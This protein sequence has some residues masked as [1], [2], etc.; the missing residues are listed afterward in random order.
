VSPQQ[1]QVVPTTDVLSRGPPHTRIQRSHV[2]R[3]PLPLRAQRDP[4]QARHAPKSEE[5]CRRS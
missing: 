4:T 2:R 1:P 5:S 3:T